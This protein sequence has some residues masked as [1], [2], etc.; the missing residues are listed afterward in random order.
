M[1]NIIK[2]Q[3]LV[4]T[5]TR[6]LLKYVFIG[7]G[8]T[9]EANTVLVDVSNLAYSLNANGMIM[10]SNTHPRSTYKTTIRR[11]FGEAKANGYIALKWHGLNNT[12]TEIVTVSDGNFDYNF[13]NMGAGA[14]IFNPNR[15]D[16]ANTTGDILI[17]TVAPGTNDVATIFIDLRKDNQDY[18][19]G[20]TADPTAFNRI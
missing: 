15:T 11:I 7:D 6:A 4:D 12:N 2:E 5:T 1:A 17:S 19:A 13:E 18:D 9:A 16:P 10:V 3:K 8:S 14:M 20:Q